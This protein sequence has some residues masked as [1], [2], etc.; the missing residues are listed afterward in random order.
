M[1]SLVVIGVLTVGAADAHAGTLSK[2]IGGLSDAAGGGGGSSGGSSSGG[3]G[4]VVGAVVEGLFSGDWGNS[5]SANDP[6]WQVQTGYAP[7][8]NGVSTQAP[9]EVFLYG[10]VQSVEG[11]DGSMTLQLRVT[12]DDLALDFRGTG[13]FEQVGSG[14]DMEQLH[15]DLGTLGGGYRVFHDTETGVWLEG[16]MGYVSSVDDL[17]F[18][19]GF[20]GARVEHRLGGDIS[21]SGEARYFVMSDDVRIL[22]AVASAKLSVLRVAYRVVDFNVGPPL[23]GP[24]V[25]VAL[26]F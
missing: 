19:G 5:R 4:D 14:E 24:E 10:G 3:A 12:Y 16:G 7:Y 20:G 17:N 6:T 22:E 26:T 13:F 25:G 2:V 9:T 15:L 8:P 23:K 21:V 11:S 1:R 18:L